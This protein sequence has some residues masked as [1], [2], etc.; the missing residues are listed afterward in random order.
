VLVV[1]AVVTAVVG[2]LYKRLLLL[3]LLWVCNVSCSCYCC[4]SAVLAV[5]VVTAAVGMLY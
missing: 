4:C 2:M 5:V 3:Q 1:V